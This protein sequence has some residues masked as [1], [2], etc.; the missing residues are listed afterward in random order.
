[1]AN[2]PRAVVELA[3]ASG[4]SYVALN[5]Y[6]RQLVIEGLVPKSGRGGGKGVVHIN[7]VPLG[8]IILAMASPGP[9]RAVET[10]Q[11]LGALEWQN[12][13][14]GDS[15]SLLTELAGEIA[16]RANRILR[17]EKPDSGLTDWALNV[18]VDPPVAWVS[19]TVGGKE[20]RRYFAP[21]PQAPEQG[22]LHMT[23]IDSRIL[24]VAAALFAD[25]LVNT[26]AQSGNA[27]PASTGPAAQ[28]G[29]DD[30]QIV[31]SDAAR[32]S[33]KARN[34]GKPGKGQ[35][36]SSRSR[37]NPRL[38]GTNMTTEPQRLRRCAA[39]SQQNQPKIRLK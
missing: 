1:M 32:S 3:E 15:G 8:R 12:P 35:G 24:N 37:K 38:Q 6:V 29:I 21:T 19:W 30:D 26:S 23:R 11:T 36:R 7:N 9:Q 14:P 18:S 16:V 2:A 39:L 20:H 10:V 33:P 4:R 34:T 22:V 5:S 27:D 28:A 17:G 31:A 25:T 13:M